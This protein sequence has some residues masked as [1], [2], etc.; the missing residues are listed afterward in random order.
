MVEPTESVAADER[1]PPHRSW[2]SLLLTAGVVATGL[3]LVLTVGVTRPGAPRTDPAAGPGAIAAATTTPS[4]VPSAGAAAPRSAVAAPVDH[5]QASDLAELDNWAR[6]LSAA[7]TLS[8]AQ[9]AAY[10][11]AE[12]WLRGEAPSCRLSWATLAG[13]G[14]A[15]AAGTGPL[16]VPDAIWARFA[17]RATQDGKPADRMNIDD[18]AYAMAR[19]LCSGG[20]DLSTAGGWWHTMLDYTRS[21]PRAAEILAAADTFAAARPGG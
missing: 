2:S 14:Q 19:Y 8:N 6:R 17:A 7:T 15:E 11:R 10:G 4:L 18:A 12:M 5:P 20:A 1:T 9:L 3:V 21:E 13:I 16:P